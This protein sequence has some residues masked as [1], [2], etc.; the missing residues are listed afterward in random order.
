MLAVIDSQGYDMGPKKD[1]R[2]VT[3]LLFI[4]FIF[5]TT[6][7]VLNLFVSVIVDKF[8]EE[9][10]RKE[11]SDSFTDEQKEWVKMQ[12]IM[13]TAKVKAVPVVPIDKKRKLC[14]TI[15]QSN[16]FE[17]FIIS[18]ISLNTLFLCMD[19]WNAPELYSIALEIANLVCVAIFAIEAILKIVAFGPRMYFHRNWN[20]FDFII[21]ILSLATI[22]PGVTT[23]NFTALRILRIA[24]LLRIVKAFKGLRNLLKALY[25]SI[26]NIANVA[27]LLFLIYFIFSVAGMDIFG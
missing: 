21:V 2:P 15:V 5:I 7:F 4:V 6:F 20:I 24:R 9:I 13:V 16:I 22:D 25:L 11:G 26:A 27:M 18:V 10:R 1:N 19:Y 3:A 14:F 17:Y 8:N 23:V 12:R